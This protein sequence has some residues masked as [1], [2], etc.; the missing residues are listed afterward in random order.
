MTTTTA[1]RCR[2][3]GHDPPQALRPGLVETG[4]R[5][6]EEQELRLVDQGP[7]QR[8]ALPLPRE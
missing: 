6:V 7:C 4:R 3:L 8:D 1:P 2:L 5:L